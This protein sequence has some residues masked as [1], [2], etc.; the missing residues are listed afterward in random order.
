MRRNLWWMMVVGSVA[1]GGEDLSKL[2][3]EPAVSDS[4]A[5]AI[6]PAVDSDPAPEVQD[7]DAEPVDPWDPRARSA[8]RA[9][10]AE[11]TVPR[12]AIARSSRPRP[13]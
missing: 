3:D 2:V 4:D 7:S 1:C 5:P 8:R 11:G 6:P 12:P 9:A 10:R 13:R